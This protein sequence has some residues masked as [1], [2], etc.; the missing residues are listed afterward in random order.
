ME[1]AYLQCADDVLIFCLDSSDMSKHWWDILNLFLMG[2]GL[3]LNGA[4]CSL[5]G[6]NYISYDFSIWDFEISIFVSRFPFFFWGGGGGN[7]CA[8]SLWGWTR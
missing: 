5:S 1:I 3:S 8:V 6:I 4:K 7:Q 2:S